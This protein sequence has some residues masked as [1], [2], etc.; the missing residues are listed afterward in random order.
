M[1]SP[2]L[3]ELR[4]LSARMQAAG[5]TSSATKFGAIKAALEAHDDEQ[6]T[7]LLNQRCAQLRAIG[8][9]KEILGEWWDKTASVLTGNT[10]AA[11]DSN[12]N[13]PAQSSTSN[14]STIEP[15]HSRIMCPMVSS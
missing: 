8:M 1:F 7:R 14:S 11:D 4:S 10:D 5:E 12:A 6:L 2:S 9:T 3:V 13:A 15:F